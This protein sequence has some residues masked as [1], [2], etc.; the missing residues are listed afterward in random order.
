M[1][2]GDEERP[3]TPSHPPT[4]EEEVGANVGAFHLEHQGV[5]ALQTNTVVCMHTCMG[6]RVEVSSDSRDQRERQPCVIQVT[7]YYA[8]AREL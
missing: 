3:P 2:R 7:V 8:Q 5:L 1:A 4:W 6:I